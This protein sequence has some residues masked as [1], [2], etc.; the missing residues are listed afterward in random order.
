MKP[1]REIHLTAD[2]K[3]IIAEKS[4]YSP[5]TVDQVL[6]GYVAPNQRHRIIFDL[7]DRIAYLRNLHR[8]NY[9]KDL[10]EL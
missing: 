9:M 6:R 2:E 3:R 4:G 10:E 8:E 1:T 7:Y 5:Y